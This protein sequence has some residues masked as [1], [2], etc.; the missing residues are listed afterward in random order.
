[1]DKSPVD[2]RQPGEIIPITQ[3]FTLHRSS[4][5]ADSGEIRNVTREGSEQHTHIS[6]A[7]CYVKYADLVALT[8]DICGFN[9]KD[10][11]L[12]RWLT[13]DHL[14]TVLFSDKNLSSLITVSLDS[15]GY[16][17]VVTL[18][19]YSIVSLAFLI[20]K[21]ECKVGFL[22][23]AF[24]MKLDV[25]FIFYDGV[26][27]I[28]AINENPDSL[29]DEGEHLTERPENLKVC[30][31][32]RKNFIDNVVNCFKTKIKA[33]AEDEEKAKG[34]QVKTYDYHD[35]IKRVEDIIND[36][37]QSFLRSVT[38]SSVKQVV[39]AVASV[40]RCIKTCFIEKN[41]EGFC[42]DRTGCEPNIADRNAKLAIRQ[43]S[44]QIS[45]KTEIGELCKC[46]SQAGV[47]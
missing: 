41:K 16:S 25:A 40:A 26:D 31:D 44:R 6:I 22:E 3:P 2:V 11:E 27:R 19:V 4:E 35:M 38:S 42:F 30:F 15:Y 18:K 46:S 20:N 47:G 12:A 29:F 33:C 24:N 45:W 14:E 1:M 10:R 13:S 8:L 43:C 37:I 32:E 36:Q 5:S 23:N 28:F 39:E 7:S 21:R 17:E 9:F 34:V